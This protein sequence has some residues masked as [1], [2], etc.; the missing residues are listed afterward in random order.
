MMKMTDADKI[1]IDRLVSLYLKMRD[2]KAELTTN[3]R[4]KEEELNTKLDAVKTTL[5]THCKDTGV[6]SVRTASGT[7][8]RTVKNKYW[9]S[10]WESMSKFIVEHKAVDL[11]EKRIHQS[12]MKQFLEE[13]PEEL[14][15]GLNVDAEYTITV[16][17]KK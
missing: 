12:N 1:G 10:D 7:F 2:K 15:S 5:L 8:Y 14:P 6:E 4:K 3:F 9:T 13:N 11:L 16:R 17:R